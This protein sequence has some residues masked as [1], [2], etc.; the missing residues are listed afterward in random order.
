MRT[1]GAAADGPERGAQHVAGGRDGARDTAIGLTESHQ[2]GGEP[3]RIGREVQRMHRVVHPIGTAIPEVLGD[4]RMPPVAAGIHAAGTD[5]NRFDD[6][7]PGG[8]APRRSRPGDR[9]L[10]QRRFVAVERRPDAA[11]R[12]ESS[13]RKPSLERIRHHGMHKLRDVAAVARRSRGPGSS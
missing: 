13:P 1:S 10:P 4:P 11:T 9:P 3:E 8:A 5:Q 12:R 6:T 7:L 2:R